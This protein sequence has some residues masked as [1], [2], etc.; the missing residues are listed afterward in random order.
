MA[1]LGTGQYDAGVPRW[2]AGAVRGQCRLHITRLPA[3][4]AY[5]ALL[6]PDAALYATQR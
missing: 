6:V 5:H 4:G 2:L 3:S 1:Y